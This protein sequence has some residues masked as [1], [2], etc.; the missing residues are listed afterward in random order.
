MPLRSLP[1][2]TVMDLAAHA[3]RLLFLAGKPL[4]PPPRP[5]P[6]MKDGGIVSRRSYR[7]L[8]AG[9]RTPDLLGIARRRSSVAVVVG[10]LHPEN[11]LVE[12]CRFPRGV[13]PQVVDQ[14]RATGHIRVDGRGALADRDL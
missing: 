14:M 8:T 11:L 2:L 13:D 10:L 1:L 6:P 7:F 9:R 5:R 3:T 4:E 12:T